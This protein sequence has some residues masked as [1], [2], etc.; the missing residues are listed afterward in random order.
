MSGIELLHGNYR[1]NSNQNLT[2]ILRAFSAPKLTFVDW[3][4]EDTAHDR[5]FPASSLSIPVAVIVEPLRQL[6][7]VH[8]TIATV[9]HEEQREHRPDNGSFTCLR[10]YPLPMHMR[11][12][13]HRNR[14]IA[15]GKDAAVEKAQPGILRHSA[16]DVRATF[17][18]SVFI[19][20]VEYHLNYCMI[21]GVDRL[22][23]G[24]ADQ[25][26]TQAMERID[27][28]AAHRKFSSQT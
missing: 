21:S 17:S 1:Q 20:K 5:S 24:E 13:S 8:G 16:G 28:L 7:N 6:G 19:E 18:R 27:A 23:I 26:H 3:V 14:M 9:S 25:S 22:I 2:V 4:P 11:A 10:R 15:I 12:G